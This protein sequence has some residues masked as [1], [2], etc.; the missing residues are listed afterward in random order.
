MLP[1]VVSSLDM[2]FFWVENLYLP[3][4]SEVAGIRFDIYTEASAL[5]INYTK[6]EK[7][8]LGDKRG[9]AESFFF[10]NGS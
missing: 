5:R 8:S 6:L 10:D 2:K 4:F 9:T 1:P 7:L 3:C